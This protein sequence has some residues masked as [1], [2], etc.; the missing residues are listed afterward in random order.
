MGIAHFFRWFKQNYSESIQELGKRQ[1]LMDAEVS[2][3]NFLID[4]NGLFHASTQKIY[5]YGSHA[6]RHNRLLSK[7]NCPSGLKAQIMVFEDICD[8]IEKLN[9]L[10]SCGKKALFSKRLVDDER[11]ILIGTDIYKSVCRAC[12]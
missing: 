2:I 6:P 10:C 8:T 5:K 9:A 7:N 11:Q 1:T 3:D 4:L 12:Y